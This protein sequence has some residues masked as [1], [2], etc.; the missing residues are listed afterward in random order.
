LV[1]RIRMSWS[2]GAAAPAAGG[3]AAAAAAPRRRRGRR[4]VGE[5]VRELVQ[6][7]GVRA[8][9][10][11]DLLV[12]VCDRLLPL[13]V[14]VQDLEEGLVDALVRREALL[15]LVHVRDGLVKLDG[16][17]GGR[18]AEARLLNVLDADLVALGEEGVEAED[19]LG[20]AVEE[21]LDLADHALGVDTARRA[22]GWSGRGGR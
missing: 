19:E 11:G 1:Q 18:R 6:Q 16:R 20:V 17:L 12:D 7:V 15:D 9:E 4:V 3:A 13:A 5:K 21:R 22:G 2:G 14:H 8:E 10:Q